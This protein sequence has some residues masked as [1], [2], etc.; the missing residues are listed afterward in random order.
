MRALILDDEKK[1][2]EYLRHL[3]AEHCPEIE[4]VLMCET[5]DQAV[6]GISKNNPDLVFLDIEL[7]KSSGFDLLRLVPVTFEVIFTTAFESY[8]L[9]AIKFSA[10]DYLLKPI[11]P[12]ELKA[13]VKKASE[14]RNDPNGKERFVNFHYNATSSPKTKRL[15]LP[16]QDG[17]IFINFSEIIRCE[18]NGA[19]TYFH[20][21]G[22]DKIL[23][24]KNIKEYEEL[25]GDSGFFRVHNSS[26]VNLEEIKKYV[27]GDGGY[28]I[29]SD[30]ASVDVSKRR[31]EAF[32]SH[33]MKL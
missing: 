17:L 28:V 26:I 27:K 15:A 29:M 6:E 21:K 16:T 33:F 3:L 8:A 10:L 5:I 31:K 1:G 24:S 12:D 13:A 23:V 19:Y 20:L 22:Q 32:L 7:N 14:K 30:D 25:L 4:T 18:A 2:R 11:D 9:K